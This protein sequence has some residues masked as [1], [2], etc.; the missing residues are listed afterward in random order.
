PWSLLL[1]GLFRFLLCRS[2]RA[3]ARRPAALGLFLLAWTWGLL[4]FSVS[5]CKRASYVLPLIPPLALTLGR[6]LA[7][8][9]PAWAAEWRSL[10]RPGRLAGGA[11]ALILV[12]SLGIV[13]LAWN[14]QLLGLLPAGLAAAGALGLL[15]ALRFAPLRSWPAVAS[16]T[17]GLLLGG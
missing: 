10:L 2:P 9:A 17:F 4:F 14:N 1:P 12:L 8:L 15:A 7:Q 16:L 13:V 6:Y 5:G 3:A 11:N